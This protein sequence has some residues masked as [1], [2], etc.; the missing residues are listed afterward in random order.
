[1]WAAPQWVSQQ[2]VSPVSN[3]SHQSSTE[4]STGFYSSGCVGV[5]EQEETIRQ[6]S[7]NHHPPQT[8]H[9][10]SCTHEQ[11]KRTQEHMRN[12]SSVHGQFSQTGT[13][14]LCTFYLLTCS[15]TKEGPTQ[16]WAEPEWVWSSGT[17]TASYKSTTKL[18]HYSQ[19]ALQTHLC[20]L[21]IHWAGLQP[22][23]DD[24]TVHR[25][26]TLCT[27][28]VLRPVWQGVGSQEQA[29]CFC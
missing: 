7:G 22:Q 23:T 3:Q 15:W 16:T 9:P 12:T 18:W 26:Y 13:N 20:H 1:M 4:D 14:Q 5:G 8:L 6:I 24:V 10:L 25:V 28:C 17:E 27:H 11:N 2:P 21:Q 29:V 19:S